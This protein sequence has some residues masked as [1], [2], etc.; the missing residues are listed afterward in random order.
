MSNQQRGDQASSS[1]GNQPA[2]PHSDTPSAGTQPVAPQPAPAPTGADV[3][4]AAGGTDAAAGA[5]QSGSKH[6]GPGG[7]S[8]RE[9]GTDAA[10]APGA[11]AG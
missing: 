3:V 2:D 10:G 5:Q 9:E 1:Q 4:G 7:A 8:L 6:G 11:L